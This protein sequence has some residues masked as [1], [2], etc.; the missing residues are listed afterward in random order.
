[1]KLYSSAQKQG[2]Q[3]LGFFCNKRIFEPK[4]YHKDVLAA[5]YAP[6]T[7]TVYNFIIHYFIDGKPLKSGVNSEIR[8]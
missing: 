4:S 7:F 5:L 1:M 8:R 2:Y 6:Q 3:K